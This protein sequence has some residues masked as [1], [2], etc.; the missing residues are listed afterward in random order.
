MIQCPKC[1]R[2]ELNGKFINSYQNHV[3][4]GISYQLCPDCRYYLNRINLIA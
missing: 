2:I 4:L 3:I 1:K